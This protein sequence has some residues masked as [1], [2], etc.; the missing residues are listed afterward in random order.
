[1]CQNICDTC[2]FCQYTNGT[3]ECVKHVERI[4]STCEVNC[5]RNQLVRK[6]S[7]VINIF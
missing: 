3:L 1:M 7:Q 6:L 5:S 4:P 2:S